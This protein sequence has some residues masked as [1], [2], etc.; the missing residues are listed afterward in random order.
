MVVKVIVF[1]IGL[2]VLALYV[3]P[4]IPIWV[5]IMA[6]LLRNS[7]RASAR[8]RS[9]RDPSPP[10]PQRAPVRGA[11]RATP[12]GPRGNSGPKRAERGSYGDPFSGCETFCDNFRERYYREKERG[13]DIYP[14]EMPPEKAPWE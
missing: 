2:A 6:V 14:W 10:S 7:A 12:P 1:L 3:P 13:R 5:I 4:L 11:S 9:G 8:K